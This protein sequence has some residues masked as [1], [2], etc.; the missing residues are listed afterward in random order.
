MIGRYFI[1]SNNIA[2]GFGGGGNFLSQLGSIGPAWQN[3]MLQGLSTQNVF[4][5]FQNKQ[6]IDPY[7]VNAVASAYGT[8]GLQNLYASEDA[9]ANLRAMEYMRNN[10][11]MN[12]AQQMQ[13]NLGQN[14]SQIQYG[15][16]LVR[17]APQQAQPTQPVTLGGYAATAPSLPQQ[18]QPPAGYASWQEYY[19]SN[20]NLYSLRQVEQRNPTYLT[21]PQEGASY[22]F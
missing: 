11:S 18:A 13:Q 8:Q 14:P 5:E 2:S 10:G 4:N 3:T 9:A 6:L 7:K 16:N 12:N 1:G 17:Q 21:A 20:P 19:S 15:Q 22:L